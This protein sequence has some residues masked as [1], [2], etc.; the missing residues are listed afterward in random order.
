MYRCK[1]MAW[2]VAVM[3][4]A[5]VSCS[6]QSDDENADYQGI[7]QQANTLY[8][9]QHFDKAYQAYLSI[10]HK[11]P[12]VYYNLG[13]CA[14]RLKKYGNALLYWR[15]AERDWG[16][17]GRGELLKNIAMV[18]E[19]VQAMR[20][21]DAQEPEATMVRTFFSGFK[22]AKNAFLSLVRAT[23]LAT[24]QLL[25]LLLWA[26][27]F[28]YVRYLYKRR[29]RVVIIL[30]FLLQVLCASMLAL[31][32]SFDSRQ[33]L[34]VVKTPAYV[35]SGP[36]KNFSVL[37]RL[38]EGQELDMVKAAD[39]YYKIRYNNTIGWVDKQCIEKI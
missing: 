9:Q 27:L 28:V 34:I 15:R 30:L 19:H 26:L 16:L 32:Y 11:S 18:K 8:K 6:A 21:N 14:Y 23:P 7:F 29:Q 37:G 5:T 17:F 2:L 10:P 20:D 1:V 36:D 4:T 13:N 31:K 24:L 3:L 25:V 12:I 38:Q 35:M 33:A 39:Q 22:K